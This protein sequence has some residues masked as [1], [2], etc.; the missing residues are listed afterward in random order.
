MICDLSLIRI[1][2][3]HFF[4]LILY[5]LVLC[6]ILCSVLCAGV[7]ADQS[8]DSSNQLREVR[9]WRAPD[10]LRLVLDFIAPFTFNH[11][12][13][14]KP[15][16]LVIDL[17]GVV[18]AGSLKSS[19]DR[20]AHNNIIRSIR[21]AQH[22][23]MLRVVIDLN[24]KISTDPFVLT[25]QYRYGYR[26]VFDLYHD[27]LVVKPVAPKGSA[28]Q[29]SVT[30]KT[31]SL[32]QLFNKYHNAKRDVLIVID[33]GHG[34]EDPGALGHQGVKEKDV[35]FSVSRYLQHKIN[36]Q[37]GF[38]AILTRT[39]DYYVGLAERVEIARE[40]D[41]DL[42]LSIH[43]NA[44]AKHKKVQGVIVFALSD[45]G[46]SSALGRWMEKSEN[47]ADL[48]GG[49]RQANLLNRPETLREVLLDLSMTASL[50]KSIEIGKLLLSEVG[51]L[52]KIHTHRVEQANFV[53]LRSPDVPSLL[54]EMGFIS[55]PNE[56]RKL[57]QA[58][59]QKQLAASL[60]RAV[61]A[62]FK[63]TPPAGT[64]LAWRKEHK[65]KPLWHRV[66]S[67]ETLSGI[68]VKYGIRI[69]VIKKLNR[70]KGDLIYPGQR[71]ILDISLD[72]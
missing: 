59:Y 34:G 43:A 56:A 23:N 38:K 53:V 8:V 70:L 50:T 36:G 42:L 5:R 65:S 6:L 66:R 44:L 20:L 28:I 69:S 3:L 61:V 25:P 18:Q 51:S 60:S 24:Y 19:I 32:D 11:F 7:Y 48:I 39:D 68:A 71:L 26:L 1:P 27:L 10:H 21:Y 49:M 45:K 29:E 62:W 40:K 58:S 12:F 4:C 33:P 63:K 52:T 72:S 13:L 47:D 30:K 64:Y 41:A 2:M 37:P 46:A 35:V 22:R 9:A 55:N 17:P 14:V 67:G 31:K 15:D 57:K 16:R 54:V